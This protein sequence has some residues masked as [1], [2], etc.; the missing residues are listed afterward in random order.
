MQQLKALKLPSNHHPHCRVCSAKILRG[1]IQHNTSGLR[2][3]HP[4]ANF[5]NLSTV[6]LLFY[7]VNL[8][9]PDIMPSQDPRGPHLF[10]APTLSYVISEQYTNLVQVCAKIIPRSFSIDRQWTYHQEVTM[11]NKS[12]LIQG[13]NVLQAALHDYERQFGRHYLDDQWPEIEV[14]AL[15]AA[16]E[17]DAGQLMKADQGKMLNVLDPNVV[18]RVYNTDYTPWLNVSPT[19]RA[20]QAFMVSETDRPT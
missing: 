19:A 3:I 11:R 14:I 1:K 8:R 6:L 12:N 2:L 16:H 17:L 7:H 13:V 18:H 15:N 10:D 5:H 20:L 4:I 9:K